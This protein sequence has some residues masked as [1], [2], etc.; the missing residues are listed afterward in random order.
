[1]NKKVKHGLI[2]VLAFMLLCNSVLIGPGIQTVHAATT[3]SNIIENGD[4]ELGNVMTAAVESKGNGAKDD[5]GDSGWQGYCSVQGA[6]F[7][8][9]EYPSDSGNNVMKMSP[10]N[11]SA[12]SGTIMYSYSSALRQ[13]V[14]YRV[15]VKAKAVDAVS[16]TATN[17]PQLRFSLNNAEY[18]DGRLNWNDV[19]DKV[20][21]DGWYTHTF[22]YRGSD[23][24]KR[25]EIQ[26]NY[27]STD[28][29][30]LIDDVSIEPVVDVTGITLNK[31][32]MAL[33]VDA[34]ETL[35]AT[36]TP[37]NATDKTVTW[38][39]SDDSI[40]TVENGKVTAIAAGTASITATTANSKSASCT[41]TVTAVDKTNNLIENGNFE[42]GSTMAEPVTST[43]NSTKADIGD[44]GWQWYA[45]KSGASFQ[46]INEDS[47]DANSNKVMKMSPFEV[48]ESGGTIMYTYGT[49]MNQGSSYKV[50]VRV[51][52]VNA[53]DNTPGLCFNLN[54][55]EYKVGRLYWKEVA[56]KVDED[57][58]YTHSFD[59]PLNKEDAKKRIEIQMYKTSTDG[60]WLIDDV[61]LVKLPTEPS[62]NLTSGTSL[63]VELG[64]TANITAELVD[65]DK[66]LGD[67]SD[68]L[69]KTWTS[70]NEEVVTVDA[71]GV[72]TPVSTGYAIITVSVE[73]GT[74]KYSTICEV[75]V[76]ESVVALT[77]ITMPTTLDLMAGGQSRL[78]ITFNPSDAT[79]KS[80]IWTSSD[81][82]VVKIQED[83]TVTA[84]KA[85]NATI[86]AASVS[87]PEISAMCTVTVTE[88]QKLTV[89]PT[90]NLDKVTFGGT[91]E[92]SL[93]DYYTITNNT[94][95]EVSYEL[96]EAPTHGYMAVEE[97]GR[98]VYAS[99]IVPTGV[100]EIGVG[101][102]KGGTYDF[103]VLVTA[104]EESA[105]L[106]GK[107]DVGDLSEV[108]NNLTTDGSEKLFF[109]SEA[110]A[111]IKEEIKID[112]GSLK[113]RIWK[114]FEAAIKPVLETIP[115][116]YADYGTA[117]DIN[118][119]DN[120]EATWQRD[121]GY[122]ISSLLAAY[123]IT[124]DTAYRDKCIEYAVTL[125]G[126]PHWGAGPNYKDGSETAG[127]N[128]FPVALVYNWL[129]D[130]LTLEQR[131]IILNRL[132]YSGE[133]FYER[134]TGRV[135]YLTNHVW[136]TNAALLSLALTLYHDAG[137]A[138]SVIKTDA[139]L[140]NID[141]N[142]TDSISA[143][144]LKADCA[145]WIAWV[146][147]DLGQTFYWMPEDGAFHE[148][149]SYYLFGIDCLLKA[150]LM[151]ESDLNIDTFTGNSFYK[152]NSEWFL[153]VMLAKDDLDFYNYF[154]DYGDGNRKTHHQSSAVGMFG[155]LA[156]KYQDATASY[157]VE[158]TLDAKAYKSG[159]NDWLPLFFAEKEI[160]AEDVTKRSATHYFSESLGMVV[161]RSDWSGKESILLAKCGIP[162]GKQSIDLLPLGKS[163]YHDDPDA[164]SLILY[165]NDEFL[166][167]S[168]G[169]G[170]ADSKHL[171]TLI[172]N[173]K[174][175]F[176]TAGLKIDGTGEGGNAFMGDDFATY[177]LEP[178][179]TVVETTDAYDYFVGDAKDAY[180]PAL[181]LKK[182]ERNYVYLKE[183][184]VLIMV[185]DIKT[186]VDQEL[187]LRWF[188]ESKE[189]D[190]SKY[191]FYSIY[192][193]KNTMNFYPFTTMESDAPEG[194]KTEWK[195]VD[196]IE[197]AFYTNGTKV[198]EKTFVQT[199]AGKE[200]QNAVAFSWA[201]G[202]EAQTQI[203]Y[204]RG[205]T[206]EH[207]FEVNGKIYT[208]NVS[209][210]TLNVAEDTLGQENLWVSDSTLSYINLND[211]R[212]DGFASET[213][214]YALEMEDYWKTRELVITPVANAPT[215]SVT[216][217][218]NGE[219]PGMVTITCTSEDKSSTTVYTLE[220]KNESGMLGISSAS[221][222]QDTMERDITHT[223]DTFIAP[224]DATKTWASQQLPVVTYDMGR[225]VD[226]TQIDVAFNN[227][228]KRGTYYTL[229]V[230]EDGEAWT[231]LGEEDAKAPQ[232]AADGP[233][234]AYQTLYGGEAQRAQYVRI[235]LRGNDGGTDKPID[236]PKD[237][238]SIQEISI[239]GTEAPAPVLQP[240][241][242]TEAT[243][244]S[245]TLGSDATATIKSTGD[246]NKFECVK[247]DGIIVDETNYTVAEGS[248]IVTFK[249]EYLETLSVGEHTVTI[250]YT[251][252]S[253]VSSELTIL[254][255][256][257]D[258]DTSDSDTTDS[259]S[260]TGDS[261]ITDSDSNTS[262]S[263][264]T[265]SDTEND[266]NNSVGNSDSDSNAEASGADV[267][268]ASG[269]NTGDNSNMTLWI[270]LIGVCMLGVLAIFMMK[271]KKN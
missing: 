114:E 109:S 33:T 138:A 159:S 41:V 74:Y 242:V 11:E 68:A 50:T 156:S 215:A 95:V 51:K 260:N 146:C 97:D 243:D 244:T 246:Y 101:H 169:Y 17:S 15:T 228:S 42:K 232:T 143:E 199:Y 7:Q 23:T 63:T 204:R 229:S 79:E 75:T 84:L 247:M 29:Y 179:M 71:N 175:Q 30:W 6:Y 235:A 44:S 32:T 39:S 20:D 184:N 122:T 257:S 267:T 239:Y 166:L 98:F 116:V 5:I 102:G 238:C 13:D 85:G 162:S 171:S 216:T 220:L 139:D 92:G 25:F 249:A 112:D 213:T 223:Y 174:G 18:K 150:S 77:G 37:D 237:Y 27:T 93:T 59:Y 58:W 180:D 160:E 82:N 70:S 209:D 161:S 241:I 88:S 12:S 78:E 125:A 251:D 80:L 135:D 129:K 195:D 190:A 81:E 183:E 153:N 151:L 178:T 230:S 2:F 132:Y 45:K 207:L 147:H 165:S 19:A 83:G 49:A 177:D 66:V 203:K 103:K 73:S 193:E 115:P 191:G 67:N 127:L 263:D 189:V 65:P 196:V 252:G 219:Y 110:I 16:D 187:E 48:S 121:I 142:Y 157:I 128:A 271:K 250:H 104:G 91:L 265:D 214:E 113:D 194:M 118:A 185:D 231:I 87:K 186:A 96:L 43:G 9:V 259:D 99:G 182:F 253:S 53:G 261:D 38:K 1:M 234:H 72:V 168:D 141:I 212:M 124:D 202:V 62:I 152:N 154:M 47:A 266:D 170:Y 131:E 22:N 262:D 56:D 172:V 26:M 111:A 227:S 270:T 145:K 10:A 269:T 240:E 31:E 148:S 3:T 218:W 167:K 136:I 256:T 200:W 176:G 224:D 21:A 226:I 130:D 248:T 90:K 40:A 89:Q 133:R 140:T 155:V 57:G 164:N 134:E 198:K 54:N 173:G 181:Y 137:Y 55:E 192:G 211:S 28:G 217:D 149:P 60:Y 123:L 61:S 86:T 126:Y 158:T 222:T 197:F 144:A 255:D 268:A 52:A 36:I 221:T 34:E 258:S 14:T 206:N 236:N 64:K 108:L 205:E 245:Y 4:F 69:K 210:N 76:I 264:T 117:S 46:V 35:T 106:T 225:L 94:G 254:A 119:G 8:V 188:P 105:V 208:L 100:P 120:K 24:K 233:L 163:E 107:V 201:P